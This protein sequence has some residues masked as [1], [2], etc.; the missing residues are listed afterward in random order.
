M[1]CD[2]F[3]RN[4][5][6]DSAGLCTFAFLLNQTKRPDKLTMQLIGLD[7]ICLG[8]ILLNWYIN[9]SHPYHQVHTQVW[10]ALHVCSLSLNIKSA[11]LL[12]YDS[13]FGF[14]LGN[15][16]RSDSVK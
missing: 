6:C 12:K 15:Y 5:H 1:A 16:C 3:M 11:F 14:M 2:V 7:C 10:F 13:P 9:A 4:E 8:I